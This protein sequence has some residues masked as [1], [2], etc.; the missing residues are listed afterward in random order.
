MENS[1]QTVKNPLYSFIFGTAHTQPNQSITQTERL[2][3]PTEAVN[4][5]ESQQMAP[6][7]PQPTFEEEAADET[8]PLLTNSN[9]DSVDEG[10]GIRNYTAENQELLQP[11]LPGQPGNLFGKEESEEEDRQI[12]ATENKGSGNTP[13]QLGAVNEAK[14]GTIRINFPNNTSRDIPLNDV[15]IIIEWLDYI[16]KKTFI[17][18]F[19]CNSCR[20]LFSI[21]VMASIFI[22]M[23]AETGISSTD[24]VVLTAFTA[25]LGTCICFLLCRI[26]F[27]CYKPLNQADRAFLEELGIDATL[28]LSD[29][30]ISPW[31]GLRE[32]IEEAQEA[33]HT[34]QQQAQAILN[35]PPTG[36]GTADLILEQDHRLGLNP[37]HTAPFERTT[38]PPLTLIEKKLSTNET[39]I[40]IKVARSNQETISSNTSSLFSHHTINQPAQ[41]L[42]SSSSSSMQQATQANNSSQKNLPF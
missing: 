8:R 21:A 41:S 22:P 31:D 17:E 32:R 10:I 42:S 35:K 26:C 39:V 40:E 13:S 33:L 29:E 19:I 34:L 15:D 37:L 24:F 14:A 38:Y 25:P 6:V 7:M 16:K 11:L 1:K 36:Q 28:S 4:S 2:E 20:L 30:H 5:T 12:R 3:I 23:R 27:K 9:Q 18:E